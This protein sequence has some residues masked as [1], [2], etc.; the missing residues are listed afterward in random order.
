[1]KAKDRDFM[2]TRSLKVAFLEA[3]PNYV[4]LQKGY[5]PGG[6]ETVALNMAHK[7]SQQFRGFVVREEGKNVRR[8]SNCLCHVYLNLQ[9]NVCA[10]VYIYL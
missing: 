5:P 2:L 9:Y 3:S 8:I 7:H 4:H 6:L 1:M 10:C